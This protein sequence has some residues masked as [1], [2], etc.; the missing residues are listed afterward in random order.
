MNAERDIPFIGPR[1]KKT[2]KP[3]VVEK[4]DLEK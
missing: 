2:G 4:S 3:E 1:A